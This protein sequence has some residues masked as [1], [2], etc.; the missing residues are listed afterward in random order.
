MLERMKKEISE[1]IK[2]IYSAGKMSTGEIKTIVENSVSKVVENSKRGAID[3]SDIAKEAILITTETL[4]S[5][6]SATKD[7]IQAS[8]N[9]TIEGISKKSKESI[10]KI[11]M[12]LLKTKYKLQEQK[13]SLAT[14]LKDGLNGAKEA[15]FTFSDVI[16][17]DIE[18]AVTNTKL[19]S[20]EILGLMKETIKHSI[21]T[22]I[23]EGEDVEEKVAHITK[24]AVENTLSSGRLSAQKTKEVSQEVIL[25]AIHAAQEAEKD[26]EKTTKGAINGAKEGV[27]ATVNTAKT[28]LSEAKNNSIDF[29]EEEIKQT[30]ENLESIEN[31]FVEA[32][33]NTTSKV[34]NLAKSVI[35]DS[36]K[37]IKTDASQ[38]KDL[39]LDTAEVAIEY[40]KEKGTQVAYST[41]EKAYEVAQTTKEE[42]VVLS[43]KMVKIAKG[44]FTG[45]VDGAKK[46]IDKK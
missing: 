2:E 45:M 38:L 22:V 20:I 41:K 14:N 21:K 43:D 4:E 27:M 12:E 11:D 23:E 30:I 46:V 44:A 8:V 17:T 9:G 28:K 1:D 31:S 6:G 35:E 24:E 10:N 3:I 32:L 19:K 42:I 5:V 33:S 26:I 25:A 40:L 29:A 36:I 16:K 37:E 39:A 7:N 34:G 13:D 15:A 18:D